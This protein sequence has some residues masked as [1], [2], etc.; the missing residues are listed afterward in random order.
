MTTVGSINVARYDRQLRLWGDSGQLRLSKAHVLIVGSTIAA[1]ETAK[2][3]I[4]PGIGAISIHFSHNTSSKRPYNNFFNS[5][6]ALQEL[7]PEVQ[8][9]TV[10]QLPLV[11]QTE[12]NSDRTQFQT[13]DPQFL[14]NFT[15]VIQS[16]P[17]LIE[18]RLLSQG[19]YNANIPYYFL[20][21]FGQIGILK[22]SLPKQGHLVLDSHKEHIL[23]DLRLDL[24]RPA[25]QEFVKSFDLESMST[26]DFQHV[27]FP[28]IISKCW[29]LSDLVAR[30]WPLEYTV[31]KNLIKENI[32]K[33]RRTGDEEN[34]QEA[35]DS[36]N[37]Y[38]QRTQV[39]SEVTASL[40]QVRLKM[41][42]QNRHVSQEANENYCLLLA[43]RQYLAMFRQLPISGVVE[44][45]TSDTDSYVKLQQIYR[46]F[47]KQDM[48]KFE[49]IL[50]EVFSEH[51]KDHGIIDRNR[52]I[53]FVKNCR[54]ISLVNTTPFHDDLT[55]NRPATVKDLE[56]DI[57]T[58][59]QENLR[60]WL[61]LKTSLL[62]EGS[63]MIEA[64]KSVQSTSMVDALAEF[65]RVGFSE[66]HSVGAITGGVAAQEVIKVITGQYVPMCGL[67]VYNGITAA[68][69]CYV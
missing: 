26:T 22:L 53:A 56:A 21:S 66:I 7:N 32:G 41:L 23:P 25:Y 31:D 37:K 57:D 43:L 13:I 67:W 10:D 68:S 36:V 35:V 5:V 16:D 12:P 34:F 4:L 48:D 45:M 39:P 9:N 6:D 69:S 11:C 65:E 54:K 51:S 15:L 49:A 52:V 29:Q 59:W 46:T 2:S 40:D 33:L 55:N 42:N 18:P 38:A 28:V 64:L 19:A 20:Y 50:E 62:T 24:P 27:P 44:D 63:G 14:Q 8:I 58:D 47:A 60:W 17:S 30:E 3:L 1:T 61:I